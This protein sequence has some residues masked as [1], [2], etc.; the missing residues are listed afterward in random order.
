MFNEMDTT[1][2]NSEVIVADTDYRAKKVLFVP[3]SIWGDLSGHRS[4]KYLVKAFNNVGVKVG[5]YAPKEGYTAEQALEFEDSFM[6]FE[7]TTYSYRH[8]IFSTNIE[9]EFLSI[10]N[11]FKPD[12][13]FYMGTIINKVTMDVCI[14]HGIKYSYLPLTTEY[15]CVKN[16]AGLDDG[17]CIQCIKSPIFSPLKNTCLGPPKSNF[18]KYFKMILFLMKSKTRI[19]N[20]DKIIGYSD[21]QLSYLEKYGASNSRMLRMPIFFDPDT[22]K[23]IASSPGDYFVMA[24]QNITAKGWHII[25]HII[26]QT[27]NIKYKLIMRDEVQATKFIH[28]ND[29]AKYIER[30]L[31]EILLYLK[32]HREVLEVVA[33]SRGVL[34]PSYY[35]TTGEFYLLEALGLGKPVVVFDAG[36]HG[37]IINNEENGMISR[38]GDLTDFYQNVQKINDDDDLYRK[39]SNG[40]RALFDELLSFQKF[41]NSMSRYFS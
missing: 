29:L 11:S 17:P 24:G 19:L 6:Y 20:A 13:V 4:S 26:K 15:Y 12:Y 10:I 35:A 16:F 21:N 30:G 1:L 9:K 2:M 32:T 5:V 27:K 7:Q 23:G 40:A 8:N 33:K 22:I 28:D 34:V 14:K 18:F 3:D 36:I 38:V 37:E 39:L 31:I 25:P 41:K